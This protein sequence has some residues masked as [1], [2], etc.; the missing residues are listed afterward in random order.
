MFS[1]EMA[2]IFAANA[3]TIL[4]GFDILWVILAVLTAWRIPKGLGITPTP[5]Y[6]SV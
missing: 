4:N 1:V 6:E 2:E 3:S 5:G